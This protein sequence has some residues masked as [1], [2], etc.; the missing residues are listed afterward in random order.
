MLRR[1]RWIVTGIFECVL[2]AGVAGIPLLLAH[3]DNQVELSSESDKD[4]VLKW[5]P[6]TPTIGPHEI[7]DIATIDNGFLLASG[8]G[9]SRWRYEEG[10]P[11]YQEAIL[12]ED[13]ASLGPCRKLLKDGKGGVWT[14]GINGVGYLAKGKKTP[15]WF[16]FK[17]DIRG[18]ALSPDGKR[19]WIVGSGGIA[20]TPTENIQWRVFKKDNLLDIAIHPSKDM[21]WCRQMVCPRNTS[22]Y[23][24]TFRFDL[25]TEQWFLAPASERYPYI[26]PRFAIFNKANDWAWF[27][28]GVNPPSAVNLKTNETHFWPCEPLWKR[29]K[30]RCVCYSDYLGQ[31]IPTSDETGDIWCASGVGVWRYISAEDHWQGYKQFENPVSGKPKL[32]QSH[33]GR[34]LYWSCDG[35]VAA[36][37]IETR[38]WRPLWNV[39]KESH[40]EAD[41]PLMLSPD[42]KMLWQ[43]GPWGVAVGDPE[44]HTARVLNDDVV[45]G[46]SE[47]KF[48]RFDEGQKLAIIAT[49]R[50]VAVTNYHGMPQVTLTNPSP[51]VQHKVVDIRFSPDGNEV[52]CLT[53]DSSGSSMPAHVY[54]SKTR[55]W[56]MVPESESK[57]YFFDVAFS[58]DGQTVWLSCRRW[59]VNKPLLL[60]RVSGTTQWKPLDVKMPEWFDNV[61][62][63]HLSPDGKELW[64]TTFGDGV[65]RANLADC[66]VTHYRE[67]HYHHYDYVTEKPLVGD[68][69]KDL[70]F[71]RKG[72]MVLC[73]AGGGG[74]EGLSLI[75]RKTNSVTNLP[76]GR[77]SS[78]E[79]FRVEPDDRTVKCIFNN[80]CSRKF[81]TKEKK[82]L[83]KGPVGVD[84]EGMLGGYFHEPDP[85]LIEGNRVLKSTPH[86]IAKV[87]SNGKEVDLFSPAPGET[88]FEAPYILPIPGSKE[89][90]CGIS[91][92]GETGIY[93]LNVT[94]RE[95]R[96]LAK[97]PGD[98]TCLKIA[99]DGRAWAGLPGRIVCLD[100][101]TR[102]EIPLW[103]EGEKR[104]PTV[105]AVKR[106]PDSAFG[107][108]T[109]APRQVEEIHILPPSDS[110]EIGKAVSL[111]NRGMVW[112]STN[113]PIIATSKSGKRYVMWLAY[114]GKTKTPP[115]GLP[116]IPRN[117]LSKAT[118]RSTSGATGL[119]VYSNDKWSDPQLLLSGSSSPHEVNAAWCM[120]EDLHVLLDTGNNERLT[121]LCFKSAE[122]QW[123]KVAELDHDVRRIVVCE[124]RVHLATADFDGERFGYRVFDTDHWS[125]VQWFKRNGKYK[126]MSLAATGATADLV[127]NEGEGVVA[128][129]A[130]GYSNKSQI[131]RQTFHERPIGSDPINERDYLAVIDSSNRLALL[132]KADLY[133]GH[134]DRNYPHICNWIGDRWSKS[135][136]IPFKTQGFDFPIAVQHGNRTL[137]SWNYV[138]PSDGGRRVHGYPILGS[139][140]TWTTPVPLCQNEVGEPLDKAFVGLH[141]D[142]QGQ[143]Y[144]A[145]NSGLD[146]PVTYFAEVT[147]LGKQ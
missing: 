142:Q 120:G 112:T 66:K 147:Q 86:G 24:K 116:L 125:D 54:F 93:R 11:R 33:D 137:V 28:S 17:G 27:S 38:T 16:V 41:D 26:G 114:P 72:T 84:E 62:K 45:M 51:H 136:K 6:G 90:L 87:D 124:N 32:V 99:P 109:I 123:T 67:E 126:G 7:T 106:P 110:G 77:I 76:L 82:W 97:Y 40:E 12:R 34:T 18:M 81:D 71:V 14:Y 143:V 48:V 129:A 65:F 78:I 92:N 107:E 94:S 132:Y 13:G 79:E 140:G 47:A 50:G 52:W 5:G 19:L 128:H 35:N 64:M 22:P 134:P 139:G 100:M 133:A 53:E 118:A 113:P 60:Q 95:L 74:E 56:Q 15:Q 105:A 138:L 2:C 25:S 146:K 31:I 1:M 102:E 127:W 96:L 8:T 39:H 141:V 37:D 10:V 83:G 145:W 88:G 70:A 144:T 44:R 63:F 130:I 122:N 30:K 58:K 121:H 46:L 115:G 43:T 23:Y 117:L 85:L 119:R 57:G 104:L 20:T 3:G 49:P 29:V 42:G 69:V 103:P 59:D 135:K 55:K 61:E 75:D 73:A 68:Y 98:A 108:I 9:I 101:V 80:G 4:S 111:D 36:F 21:A 89:Y 131:Y 91:Q